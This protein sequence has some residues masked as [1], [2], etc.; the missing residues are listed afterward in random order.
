V[1]VAVVLPAYN[2][3]NNLTPLNT[4]ALL[5]NPAEYA[6]IARATSPF[7]DGHAAQRIADIL[8]ARIG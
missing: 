5:Y 7:G 4:L 1:N 6:L 8:E 3:E 2:E